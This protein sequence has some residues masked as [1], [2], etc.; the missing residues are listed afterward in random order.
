MASEG[1]LVSSYLSMDGGEGLRASTE[2]LIP[3]QGEES[4]GAN[5]Q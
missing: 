1:Q 3:K 4:Q 2:Q 5:M